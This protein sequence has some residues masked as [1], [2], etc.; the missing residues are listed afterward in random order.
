MRGAWK[1]EMWVEK[2]VAAFV[3]DAIG[4]AIP[5]V[6]A[7]DVVATPLPPSDSAVSSVGRRMRA[8]DFL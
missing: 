1:D 2:P 8:V 5:R 7:M 3:Q 6:D 4:E